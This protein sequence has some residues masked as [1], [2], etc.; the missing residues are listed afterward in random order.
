MRPLSSSLVQS[1]R[2]GC[3]PQA[4]PGTTSA[5]LA[6][7]EPGAGFPSLSVELTRSHLPVLEPGSDSAEPLSCSWLTGHAQGRSQVRTSV[8][9]VQPRR[10]TGTH[11]ESGDS[12]SRG[13][14][15]RIFMSSSVGSQ[16]RGWHEPL[17]GAGG[18]ELHGESSLPVLG[19]QRSHRVQVSRAAL[20]P[21]LLP[22]PTRWQSCA[23]GVIT[24]IAGGVCGAKEMPVT[25]LLFR[26]CSP[27]DLIS[28]LPK[29]WVLVKLC[30]DMAEGSLT[31]FCWTGTDSVKT[32][33]AT[34]SCPKPRVSASSQPR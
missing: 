20:P 34:T 23:Q 2:D 19:V 28:T 3:S 32:G 7:L 26:G 6:P 17:Q 4:L 25:S 5:P 10:E 30:I 14:R 16:V 15:E 18:R 33:Q 21:A 13:G 9:W 12:P 31:H 27:T 29:W 22:T 1:Y 8:S 11:V 24:F